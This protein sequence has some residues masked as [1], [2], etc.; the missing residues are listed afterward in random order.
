MCI[1][2][3]TV[4]NKTSVTLEVTYLDKIEAKFNDLVHLSTENL[5]GCLRMSLH[6]MFEAVNVNLIAI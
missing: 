3:L 4:F 5:I 6:F 2:N 1:V